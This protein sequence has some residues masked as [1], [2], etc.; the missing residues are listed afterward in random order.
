MRVDAAGHVDA[1]H[2][3]AVLR[4]AE[5]LLGGNDAC[6]QDPLVV[7]DVGDERVQGPHALLEACFEL[8][9]LVR[10]QNA[11]DDVE[12]N[13]PLRAGVLAVDRERDPDAM[14]QRVGFGALLGKALGG[15][16]VE[17]VPIAAAVRARRARRYP[18]SRRTG[19]P[20]TSYAPP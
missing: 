10:R 19:W 6:L 15:L 8:A 16:L 11:R 7:V 9:P 5:D 13:Q 1:L 12:G 3:G 2:L 20:L 14:E 4:V 18:A 17:P